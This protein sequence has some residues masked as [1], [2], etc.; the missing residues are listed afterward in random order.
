VALIVRLTIRKCLVKLIIPRFVH[1]WQ[2]RLVGVEVRLN[3]YHWTLWSVIGCLTSGIRPECR[4]HKMYS[5]VD[6]Q[7]VWGTCCT[8]L[9]R[10]LWSVVATSPTSQQVIT[11]WTI[12]LDRSGLRLNSACFDS[13]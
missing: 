11:A 1:C 9:L 7:Q 13:E 5:I 6:R 8:G 2:M 12:A 4:H 3:F 10:F